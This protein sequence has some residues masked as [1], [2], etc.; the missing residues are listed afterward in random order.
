MARMLA[1]AA[2]SLA[3]AAAGPC[4]TGETRGT[5]VAFVQAW[6]AGDVA[7]AELL[8]AREPIFKWFSS[9]APARG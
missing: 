3:L 2:A 6:D 1:T 9:G 7:R 8:V 5:F 4:T